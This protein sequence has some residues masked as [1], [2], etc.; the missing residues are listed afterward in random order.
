MSE[1]VRFAATVESVLIEEGFDPAHFVTLPPAAADQVA[2]HLLST[3]LKRGF[4]SARVA[5]RVGGSTWSTTLNPVKSGAG[6]T[7]PLKKPVRLA[8]GFAAGDSIAVELRLG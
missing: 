2:A 5:A 8:E 4:G 3:N 7:L 6:W 1:T